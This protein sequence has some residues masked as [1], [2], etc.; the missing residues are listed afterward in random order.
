MDI[1][2]TRAVISA[3]LDG[4]IKDAEWSTDDYFGFEI[5]SSV[6][7][8][9]SAL[10]NPSVAWEDKVTFD[11]TSRHLCEM[12]VAN[13]MQY[14]DG[15]VEDLTQFGP[16]VPVPVPESSSRAEAPI[17]LPQENDDQVRWLCQP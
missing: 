12:F 16:V 10:L 3:I 5:P 1:P 13:F 8:V 14:Q 11:E 7:G 9:K 15:I 2:I 17:M 6:N 4:S